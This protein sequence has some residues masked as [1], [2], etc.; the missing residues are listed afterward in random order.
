MKNPA[1]FYFLYFWVVNQ[2]PHSE[3]LSVKD[4]HRDDTAKDG[5]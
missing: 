5:S 1:A 2:A 4:G 3:G